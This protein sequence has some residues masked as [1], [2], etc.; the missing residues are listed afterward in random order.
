MKNPPHPGELIRE[1]M[2]ARGWSVTQ[3]A[4]RL[5]CGRVALSCLLNGRAGVSVKMSLA[6]ED[7]GWGN[8]EQW[9]RL[10]AIYN[11]SAYRTKHGIFNKT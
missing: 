11:L 1:S 6:L 3:T 10:Q 5:G 2:N 9:V 7:M 8:A 4:K